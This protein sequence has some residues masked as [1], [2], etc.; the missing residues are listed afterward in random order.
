MRTTYVTL[1]SMHLDPELTSLMA[2]SRDYDELLRAW[3]GWHDSAGDPL[4]P[5]YPQFVELSNRGARDYGFA[6]TKDFWLSGYDMPA[7]SM[8]EKVEALWQ[9]LTPFYTKLHCFVRSKLNLQYGSARVPLGGVTHWE[10]GL[11]LLLSPFSFLF[12]V[13]LPRVLVG[14]CPCARATTAFPS[15]HSC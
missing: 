12:L 1:F 15:A 7:P 10:I 13:L 5:L 9:Q 8:I 2:T 4:R 3:Q 14:I 6:D 11:P